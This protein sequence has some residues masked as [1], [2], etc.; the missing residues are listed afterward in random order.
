MV[1]LT[2]EIDREEIINIPFVKKHWS[3]IKTLSEQ[4]P[5]DLFGESVPEDLKELTEAVWTQICIHAI[6]QQRCENYVQL[7]GLISL[8]GVGEIRRTN[9]AII[10]ATIIRKFNQWGLQQRNEEL[11]KQGKPPIKRLQG[12]PKTRLFLQFLEK[13]CEEADA[14]K[15]EIGCDTWK[16]ISKNLGKGDT[17][18]SAKE[19]SDKLKKFEKDLTQKRKEN[20]AELP[21]GI[22]V[23]VALDGKILLRILTKSNNFELEV[24]AEMKARDI[25]MT[26]K[27]RQSWSLAEKRKKI[28]SHEW[29]LLCAADDY[30]SIENKE[31]DV[32]DIVPLSEQLSSKEAFKRQGDILDKAKGILVLE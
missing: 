26:K 24:D 20:K 1:Y 7:A 13:F 23:T 14:A 5:V 9:R 8:T 16:K 17:K 27:Q 28:R 32:K 18:A 29:G 15:E 11:K 3:L 25:K 2:S 19:R 22:D 10:I 6:H 4:P 12:S 31:S 30:Y 21:K